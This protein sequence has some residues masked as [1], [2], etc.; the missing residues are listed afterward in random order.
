[1]P[2]PNVAS[3]TDPATEGFCLVVMVKAPSTADG[4]SIRIPT[5]A[6][7]D[8]RLWRSGL[9][10]FQYNPHALLHALLA[11]RVTLDRIPPSLVT[12]VFCDWLGLATFV[13]DTGKGQI[14]RN[15]I[16]GR[17]RGRGSGHMGKS[18]GQG[19]EEVKNHSETLQMRFGGKSI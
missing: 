2:K 16:R 8:R 10:Q 18:I 7:T 9:F 15:I 1:M 11:D 3:L 13:A 19:G 14:F 4:F 6:L 12:K 5:T 17:G